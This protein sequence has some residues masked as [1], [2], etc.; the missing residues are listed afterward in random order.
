MQELSC[1]LMINPF[2]PTFWRILAAVAVAAAAFF[3]PQEAPLEWYPLNNPGDDI[4]Y[5]EITCSADKTDGLQIFYNTTQ[6]INQL[7]SI[8]IP[9]APS[10]LP[11]TYTFPL[12][13]APIVELRVDPLPKGG[14]LFISSMRIINRRN[15]EIRR[16]TYDMFRPVQQIAAIRPAKDGWEIISTPEADD[17]ISRIEL[18]SPIIAPGMDHRNFL[19]SL[20]STSYLSLMLWILLIAVQFTLYRPTGWKDGAGCLGFMAVLAISF[21]TVGNRG[22]I[23]NSIHYSRFP[24]PESHRE[25]R[26]EMDLT[27]SGPSPTQLFTNIGNGINEQD[28]VR[29]GYEAHT[30]LQTVRF[31]LPDK[32]LTE[33]RFDPRDNPGNVLIR[34]I[35][36]VDAGQRTR[37]VLPLDSLLAGQQI[38]SLEATDEGLLIKTTPRATD[39]ILNFT[40]ESLGNIN[41]VIERGYLESRISK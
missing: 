34:G 40:A 31:P 19:R 27:S 39:A 18:Y 1:D 32:P 5:L 3:I 17:P 9:I 10:R 37:A 15:E 36:I 12:R 35:R 8:Y 24:S 21:A 29:R 28:S 4:F 25:L 16:F 41:H 14:K 20:Y 22:L 33:L 26:L 13:D 6:G 11:F 7:D 23:R 2:Q 30:F 38:A